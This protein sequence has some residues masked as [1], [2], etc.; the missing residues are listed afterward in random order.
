MYL[1]LQLILIDWKEAVAFTNNAVSA[2][3]FKC[4]K[5]LR[6]VDLLDVKDQVDLDDNELWLSNSASPHFEQYMPFN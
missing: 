6:G 1:F 2:E 5:L 3:K 4:R